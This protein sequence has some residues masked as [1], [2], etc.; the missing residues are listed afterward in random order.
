VPFLVV[1]GT[2]LATELEC[3]HT[4]LVGRGELTSLV[5]PFSLHKKKEGNR[6]SQAF[7]RAHLMICARAAHDGNHNEISNADENF[8]QMNVIYNV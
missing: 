5:K 3:P 2:G 4:L 8:Y 7:P 1:S 6:N